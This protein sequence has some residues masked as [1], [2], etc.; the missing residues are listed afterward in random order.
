MHLIII[1]T[2]TAEL[3]ITNTLAMNGIA[4]GQSWEK[5]L[6]CDLPLISKEIRTV[7]ERVVKDTLV[8]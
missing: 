1:Y 4:V 6:T 8:R 2:G 5:N 3:D 7:V